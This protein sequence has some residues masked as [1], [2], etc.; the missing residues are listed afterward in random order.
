MTFPVSRQG[1][2]QIA[3]LL[4]V[5]SAVFGLLALWR[6][7]RG[8]VWR[9]PATSGGILVGLAATALALGYTLAPNIPTPPVPLTARFASNPVPDTEAAVDA[10]RQTY[11]SKCAICHG[12]RAR[13]DGPAA[14]TL[15]PKPFD[16][17]VH[18]PQHATG[19]TFYWISEGVAGT[20]MPAWKDQ[21]TEQERWEVIRFLQAL[22]S[23]RTS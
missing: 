1:L 19:E 9:R 7:R 8:T 13:G 21:L 15:N 5:G 22:A 16:L 17:I 10:G 6:W 2:E 20:G 11:Q 23:G 4:A 14:L 12:P 18:V 3:L